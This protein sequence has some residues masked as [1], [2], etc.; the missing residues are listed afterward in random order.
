[1]SW[2]LVTVEVQVRSIFIGITAGA[3]ALAL[4]T[5]A[6]AEPAP[7]PLPGGLELVGALEEDPSPQSEAFLAA[8]DAALAQA[9]AEPDNY[10][11]PYIDATAGKVILTATPAGYDA[12]VA[13]IASP[14][15]PVDDW[16]VQVPRAVKMVK[17]SFAQLE[18]IKEDITTLVDAGVPDAADIVEVEPDDSHNRLVITVTSLSQPLLTSLAARYGAQSIAIRHSPDYQSAGAENRDHNYPSSFYAGAKLVGPDTI[19]T[20]G[21]SW[22]SGSTAMMLTAG[23]CAANGGYV[24]TPD[25]VTMGLVDRDSRE[26][27]NSGVGT[28]KLTGQSVNR[29]DL[30]LI[31]VEPGKT[32]PGRVFRG[33]V[34]SSSSAAVKEMWARAAK[35][36]DTYCTGGF[37][38][39]EL[40]GW[41]V[42]KTRANVKYTGNKWVRNITEGRKQGECTSPGDSGGPIYTVRS[43]GGVSA[44][45]IHSGGGGGGA[46]HWGGALD[47][48]AEYFTDI[49]EAY[50]GF[51]GILKTG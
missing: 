19:C 4:A 18:Q 21:F 17:R 15:S 32:A 40:C 43:D 39:G 13:S 25:G 28:V 33:G 38:T 7:T 14:V 6:Y 35:V 48:C 41:K 45:G 46:D 36:G 37:R 26:N 20:T 34:G 29:G 16:V 47:P 23:H 8:Q 10:G 22:V 44:K 12:A 30:A 3:V 31:Q 11:Y 50:D 1:L 2:A 49:R 24:K 5:P 9:K 27:W 51:P 42:V